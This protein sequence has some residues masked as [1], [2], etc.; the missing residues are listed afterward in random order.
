MESL[1]TDSAESTMSNPM[2][3]L[4]ELMS[5]K[6][7]ITALERHLSNYMKIKN[8]LY[9]EN[10]ELKLKLHNIKKVLNGD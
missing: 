5:D 1:K 6:D 9:K 7:K 8:D 3:K 4:Y 10:T 2:P